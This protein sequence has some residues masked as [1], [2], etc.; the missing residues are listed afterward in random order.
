MMPVIQTWYAD[1]YFRS[2][3]EARWAVFFDLL[4]VKWEYEKEGYD[5]DGVWYLPDFWLPDQKIWI[6][7][8][9]ESP[10]DD[11]EA[12]VA[13]LVEETG[14]NGYILHGT[15]PGD[16]DFANYI[17]WYASEDLEGSTIAMSDEGQYFCICPECGIFGIVYSGWAHRLSCTCFDEDNRCKCPDRLAISTALIGA[18]SARFEHG[19]GPIVSRSGLLS[20]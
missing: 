19:E 11:E 7:I 10:T 3:L 4:G 2:R 20:V 6:E 12:K 1:T 18:R 5:L 9:G 15:I 17:V 8:K 13:A 14:C 16:D